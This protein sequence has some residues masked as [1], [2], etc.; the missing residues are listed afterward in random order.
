[1][2]KSKLRGGAKAHRARVAKRNEKLKIERKQAEKQ[3]M[4]LMEQRLQEFQ[5]KFSGLTE[6]DE[7]N[8]ENVVEALTVE[9]PTQEDV[10]PTE[11]Q[12]SEL[13]K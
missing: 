6:T 11:D 13:E 2:P 1:M 8:A 3:Y 7:L 9:E 4:Q 5:N 10:T 12:V